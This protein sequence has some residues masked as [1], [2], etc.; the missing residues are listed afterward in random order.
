[1]DGTNE[2]DL[3]APNEIYF[4]TTSSYFGGN[5]VLTTG[6]LDMQLNKIENVSQI[7][8][9]NGVLKIASGNQ[10]YIQG[11]GNLNNCK[12]QG[13]YIDWNDSTGYGKMHLITNRGGGSGGFSFYNVHNQSNGTVD[14]ATTKEVIDVNGSG[15]MTLY[16]TT[17]SVI[18]SSTDKNLDVGSIDVRGASIFDGV[19]TAG[20]TTDAT[21]TSYGGLV[22]KGGASVAKQLRVTG[23]TTI[24]NTTDSTTINNGALVVDGGIGCEK[25]LQVGGSATINSVTDATSSLTGALI[26]DGG[27]S[28]V[29][30]LR[31]GG[32]TTL[33]NTAPSTST[34]TG[35]LV[36]GGGMGVTQDVHI[37]G[38]LYAGGNVVAGNLP[39]QEFHVAQVTGSSVDVYGTF[40]LNS[41]RGNTNYAV[42]TTIY[43]NLPN[44]TGGTYNSSNTSSAMKQV[45]IS[46]ITNT[47]FDWI[48]RKDTGD[49]VNC[50]IIFWVVFSG[51]LAYQK[52]QI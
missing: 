17:D 13:S 14:P 47:A 32:V 42:F 37:G 50:T 5:V 38:T 18:G 4:N 12:E 21:T 2:I 10:L 22:V 7:S 52:T 8:G 24:L 43:E 19:A 15:D 25:S 46:N 6:N 34:A 20:N 26:V 23:V 44:G 40:Q 51:A 27:A 11:Y 28:V 16:S 36:I 49:N 1:M 9:Y 45:I 3:T 35:A 30:Q 39:D 31:V 29:K 41:N 33:S 48:V